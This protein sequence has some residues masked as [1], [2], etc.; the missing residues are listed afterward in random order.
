M[1]GLW[2]GG[3]V[4]QHNTRRLIAGVGFFEEEGAL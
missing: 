2:G 4:R 1:G 3:R